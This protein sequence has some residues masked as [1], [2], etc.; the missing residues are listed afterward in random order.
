MAVLTQQRRELRLERVLD[1]EHLSVVLNSISVFY[2]WAPKC[3]DFLP[4]LT[5]NSQI[6]N[7]YFTQGL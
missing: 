1:Q 6:L 5:Q 2:K 7:S 3:C 4:S